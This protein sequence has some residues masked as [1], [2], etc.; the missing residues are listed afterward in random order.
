M[1]VQSYIYDSTAPADH[2]D[3]VRERLATRDEEFES[4]D[5]ADADDRSDAVREAMFAIRESVRI[6]TAPDEL[7]NDNGEPDF[8]PGVLITAAPTGRRTIHVGR[9][10]LEALAEDEP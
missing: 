7:Y 9:E 6:G 1:R 3:R 5:V 4:L 8:A 10:A 2:V